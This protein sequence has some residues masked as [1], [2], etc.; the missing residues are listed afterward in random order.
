MNQNLA[1]A[2]SKLLNATES[3]DKSTSILEKKFKELPTHRDLLMEIKA[4]K[5]QIF[6]RNI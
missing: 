1:T 3:L 2:L 6:K 5:N 4:I